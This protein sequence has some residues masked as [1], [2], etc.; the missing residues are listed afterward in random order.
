MT[1]RRLLAGIVLLL[2]QAAFSQSVEKVIFNPKD[3]T[4][5]HYLAV[6]PRG[7]AIGGALVLLTSFSAP[8]ALLP[9][10]KLHNVA[11]A[12]DLLTV[13]VATPEKLYAD[14]PAVERIN[15]VLAHVAAA[16]QV[17]TGRFVLA[18]YD[19]AGPVALR[20]TELTRQQPSRFAV[21]PRAV[22]AIDSPVDVLELWQ[23]SKRQ[24]ARN[25]PH[26]F[27]GKYII[28]LMTKEHGAADEKREAYQQLTPV[29]LAEAGP[30]N[31]RY[32]K[33]VPV[34]LYYDVDPQWH[35]KERRSS[36]YDTHLP[37][38]TE[39]IR[40]LLDA[41]NEHAELVTAKKPGVGSNGVRNPNSL[42]I[43]DEVECIHWI[44]GRLGLFDPHTWV[45]PYRLPTPKGWEVE[46]FP[47][48]IS[49]APQIPYRGVEDVRFAPGWGDEK[50]PQYWSYA[51]LWWLE[52]DPKIDAA[53]LEKHLTAYYEGLVGSNVTVRNI[54]ADKVVATRVQLKSTRVDPD[55][56]ATYQGTVTMLDYMAQRPVTLHCR[57]GVRRCEAAGRTVVFFE[58]SPQPL[59]HAVWNDLRG[60]KKG[61]ACAE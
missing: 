5:G 35:L 50:S 15:A 51:Y 61:F 1:A 34:R 52:D 37:G 14:G 10:T 29:H 30:G 28:D 59:E 6:R 26:A 4:A 55:D 19:Y 60:L 12:N 16:Y 49:F 41:G 3:T 18:G 2:A 7:E 58:L 17:D 8:E 43:V 56:A 31:E 53:A 21:R 20:Y 57:V 40:R 54:P 13:V 24:V 11:Y 33:D 22:M 48:P 46:R 42:S 27:A 23:W 47:I 32:L 38:G 39:L 36:L 44:K 25:S 45:P 9:E